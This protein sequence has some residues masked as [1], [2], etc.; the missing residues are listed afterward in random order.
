MFVPFHLD[1]VLWSSMWV[2]QI[3]RAELDVFNGT[4]IIKRLQ[5][6]NIPRGKL[7]RVPSLHLSTSPDEQLPCKL[8]LSFTNSCLPK[9]VRNLTMLK[10]TYKPAVAP[11]LL[12]AGWT[13]HRAP[14]GKS[15]TIDF[16]AVGLL[17]YIVLMLMTL[18]LRSSVLLQCC[19]TTVHIHPPCRSAGI[20]NWPDTGCTTAGVY[21]RTWTCQSS[22]PT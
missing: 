19:N 14:T 10:S 7:Q 11:P 17:T 22:T 12:P 6:R 20:T 3:I 16:H 4:I 5:Y 2:R 21:P 9:V 15:H 8:L 13:E 1:F 18:G